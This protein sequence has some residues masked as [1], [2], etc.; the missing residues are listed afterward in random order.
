MLRTISCLFNRRPRKQLQGPCLV[1]PCVERLEDRLV[2]DALSWRGWTDDLWTN[3]GN[4]FDESTG[5]PA[6]R[7]PDASDVVLFDSRAQGDCVIPA[8]NSYAVARLEVQSTFPTALNFAIKGMLTIWGNNPAPTWAD[9]SE[10]DRNI[11]IDSTGVLALNGGTVDWGGGSFDRVAGSSGPGNIYVYNDCTVNVTG[12]F[13]YLNANLAIGETPDGNIYGTGGT[14]NLNADG[15]FEADAPIDIYS[16]GSLN[17]LGTGGIAGNGLWNAPDVTIHEMA[18]LYRAGSQ[19]VAIGTHVV[20]AGGTL[21]VADNSYLELSAPLKPH[22]YDQNV[23][24]SAVTRIGNLAQLEVV[25]TFYMNQGVLEGAGSSTGFA[26]AY[27]IADTVTIEGGTI[28]M[29][30]LDS[31]QHSI[32]GGELNFLHCTPTTALSKKT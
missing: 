12:D 5:N 21:E 23:M 4:W 27:L 29:G 28:Q 17:L 14:V 25:G 18:T 13:R 16:Y 10:I 31:Y 24:P 26:S 8:G 22:A 6:T 11:Q 1:R 15:N 7:I 19:T 30:M 20:N 32:F 3:E 2:L 9:H